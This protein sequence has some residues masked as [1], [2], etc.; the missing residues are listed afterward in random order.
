MKSAIMTVLPWMLRGLR[1][2]GSLF[3]PDRPVTRGEFAMMVEDVIIKMSGDEGLATR[4]IS[5]SRSPFADLESSSPYFNSAMVSTVKGILMTDS[6]S[7][8]GVSDALSGAD[9][10]L[11]M[12]E[13]KEYRW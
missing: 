9:A 8:F 11:A 13:L 2:D 1:V 3:H 6:S 12:R 4:Y 7:R 10:L 5:E